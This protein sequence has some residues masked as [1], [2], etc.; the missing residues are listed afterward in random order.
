MGLSQTPFKSLERLPS[1]SGKYQYYLPSSAE[2]A[3]ISFLQFL[4]LI[5][6]PLNI[7]L[8]YLINLHAAVL[9]VTFCDYSNNGV[10][11]AKMFVESKQSCVHKHAKKLNFKFAYTNIHARNACAIRKQIKY[12]N[13]LTTHNESTQLKFR[14]SII[15]AQE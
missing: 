15:D 5:Q 8:N 4:V 12:Q 1:T 3:P 2:R 10:F 11:L 7:H 14:I 13:Y 6:N 9:A